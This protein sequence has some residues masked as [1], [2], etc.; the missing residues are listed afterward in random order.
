MPAVMYEKEAYDLSAPGL[1]G[2]Q[3]AARQFLDALVR[4]EA[5][6]ELACYGADQRQFAEFLALVEPS[7]PPAKTIH[8]V[9]LGD[10]AG[11]SRAGVLHLYHPELAPFL[12]KRRFFGQRLYSVAGIIHSISGLRPMEAIGDLAVAPFQPWD[13]LICTSHAGRDAVAKILNGWVDYLAR[14]FNGRPELNVTLPVIPLGIDC[15]AFVA[16]AAPADRRGKIRQELGVADGDIA[17]LFVGRL[18]FRRKCHPVPMYLA[19]QE[20][21]RATGARVHFIQ[22]GQFEDDTDAEAFH[23]AAAVFCP[24]VRTLV[25]GGHETFR[26]RDVWFAGDIFLS[27]SDNI[28]ETFGLAPVEAMAVGLP[29]VVSEWDGYRD[30]VRDGVDGFRVPTIVPPPGAGLDIAARYFEFGG[31]R[32]FYGRTAMSTV[33][34]IDAAAAALAQ[35]IGEPGLRQR[36][37][38]N[39]RRRARETYD[40]PVILNSY[41]QLWQVLAEARQ[42]AAVA[43]PATAGGSPYPLCDDPYRVFGG[44]AS[45]AI[46]DDD[47]LSAGTAAG[48]AGLELLRR[49]P[50]TNFAA[51]WRVD[52]AEIDDLLE[53]VGRAGMVSVADIVDGAG[54]AR[55]RLQRTIGY[56][57]KF[58]LLRIAKRR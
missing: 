25:V 7:R 14:R 30:T 48:A 40:W 24:D 17:V 28:Q 8:R 3:V 36:L 4:D 44:H 57:L 52:H 34:D 18:T 55:P 51:E 19:L 33:V 53:R 54:A 47:L 20:A 11:L 10:H 12:W 46:A 42:A 23:A 38:E 45:R 35:L 31:F 5:F 56:L 58:G 49:S 39:G 43:A 26:D 27:L 15:D 13:A 1:V 9:P 6:D 22:A 50:L 37:G 21:Q 2:A 32:D 16:G 41:H 29:V